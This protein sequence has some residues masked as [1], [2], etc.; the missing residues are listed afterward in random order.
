MAGEQRVYDH[1]AKAG[2][3]RGAHLSTNRCDTLH[4]SGCCC[5]CRHREQSLLSCGLKLWP[6]VDC[7][8]GST[9]VIV[10]LLSLYELSNVLGLGV[11][12]SYACKCGGEGS[13]ELVPGLVFFLPPVLPA[14]PRHPPHT[15]RHTLP[16]KLTCP[17]TLFTLW[18]T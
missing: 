4:A 11:N 6:G 13:M 18:L 2:K 9:I 8:E 14:Q 12:R 5:C 7:G 17:A 16:T 3:Y 15:T 1:R 10:I